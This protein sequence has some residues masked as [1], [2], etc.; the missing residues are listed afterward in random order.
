MS[1]GTRSGR[2]DA[3]VVGGGHNALV[4]AAYLARAGR[5]CLVIERRATLGGAAV[6]A[7]V[8]EGVPRGCRAT[9]T[10]SACSPQQIVD[11]LGLPVRLAPPRASPRTRPT[12]APPARAACSST[13]R[14]R[15]DRPLVRAVTGDDRE[16]DG[17]AATSTR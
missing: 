4:A 12:R 17:L 2:W 5:S 9:P 14:P 15:R 11:D 3:V 8:F 16:P 7:A 10:S 13:R 6:S 1:A